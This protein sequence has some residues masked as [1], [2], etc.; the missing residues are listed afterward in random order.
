[1]REQYIKAREYQAKINR[2]G[3]DASKIPP[4]DLH[5][6]TL[7]EAMQGKRVVHHHTH[8]ADDIMTAS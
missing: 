1:M 8:R 4:R 2:A 5:L 6:E 7:V 3:D